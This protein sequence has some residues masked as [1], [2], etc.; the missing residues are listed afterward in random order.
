MT[1]EVHRLSF[2]SVAEHYDRARPTYPAEA[3]AWAVGPD[4]R[5]VLDLGAGTGL[6][7]RVGLSLGLEMIAVEPDPGMRTRFDAV[8]SGVTALAGSAEEIPLPD[9]SVDAV[10]VGQAYHWFDRER[11]H[12][13]IARV[14]RPGGAFAPIWNS[15]SSKEDWSKRLDEIM[16]GGRTPPWST[17]KVPDF[18]PLFTP[19]E[20]RSFT[21]SVW[22]T[23]QGLCDLVASRSHYLVA[24]PE[25]QA[26][27]LAQTR[28]L[29][30][31]LPEEGFEFPYT[32]FVRR[33]L[34]R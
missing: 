19:I 21:H 20:E 3:V 5:R 10:V 24:P 15:R 14:L 33:A 16:N 8:T 29:V 4:A 31:H 30:E 27:M 22:Q 13:E 1:F 25:Q 12:P 2:G 6:L 32:T 23:R 17:A 18:G 9:G 28:E 26:E 34:R 7:T 11:A